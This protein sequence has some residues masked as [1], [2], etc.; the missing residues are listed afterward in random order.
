MQLPAARIARDITRVGSHDIVVNAQGDLPALE[1]SYV[2][3]VVEAL[4]ETGADIATLAA[5]L[6]DPSDR[7]NAAVV[8]PV[9]AWE[10]SGKRGHALYFTRAPAPWGAGPLFY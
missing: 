7:D 3:D 9:V 5:E 10:R 4:D 2:H 8:K 6:D 1:P